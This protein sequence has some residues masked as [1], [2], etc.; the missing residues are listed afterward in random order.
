MSSLTTAV[1]LMSI[2]LTMA[3]VY[4][5]YNDNSE[6]KAQLASLERRQKDSAS[7][8]HIR[9][10]AELVANK[11]SLNGTQ[12]KTGEK[13]STDQVIPEPPMTR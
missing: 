6:I 12:H 8:D 2:V 5:L 13:H 4:S 11:S 10:I 7:M 9:V 3:V 1:L